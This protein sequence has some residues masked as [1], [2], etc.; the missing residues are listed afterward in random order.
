MPGAKMA[1]VL[2]GKRRQGSHGIRLLRRFKTRAGIA[3]RQGYFVVASSAP[4]A[5][6]PA[7]HSTTEEGAGSLSD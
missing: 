7:A 1:L 4:A 5:G 6:M 2:L 3:T